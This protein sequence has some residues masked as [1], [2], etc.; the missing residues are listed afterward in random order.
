MTVLELFVNSFSPRAE[1]ARDNLKR[2]CE[3]VL[4]G[5]PHE[6]RVIDV[7]EDPEAAEAARVVATPLLIRRAP[8]PEMRFIGDMA[9]FAMLSAVL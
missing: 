9:D 7:I 6:L 5:Q 4:G 3:E 2:F 8:N 1:P